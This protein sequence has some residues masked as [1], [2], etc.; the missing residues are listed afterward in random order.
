MTLVKRSALALIVFTSLAGVSPA[1]AA[2]EPP[3]VTAILK[4]WE[5]QLKVKPTYQS[6]TTESDG[7]VVID[8][9]SANLAVPN[10]PA[11]KMSVSVGKIK[12]SG[13]SDKGNGLFE[14]ASAQYTDTK[15]DMGTPEAGFNITVPQSSAEYW[16]V[17]ALG[18]NPTPADTLRANMNIA[19]KMSAGTMTLTAAGQT[20][21]ADG[22]EMTWDGDPATGSGKT[23]FKIV[24]ITIPEAAIAALDPSGMLKQLGYS[25]LAF[26]IGGNGD[27]DIGADKM[28]FNFDMFY[29]GKDMGTLKI[30]AGMGEIPAALL[31]ELQKLEGQAQPD[32][33]KFMPLVQGIQVSR[34]T[35]RFEDQSI[36]K[37]MIPL[38]AKMQNM[39]E[40]TMVANAGAMLQLGLAELKNPTFT[41]KAVEAVNAYLKDPRSLTILAKPA[42]PVTVQQLMALDPNNPGAAIDQLGVTISAND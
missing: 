42:Q 34:V 17:K 2:E 1:F 38:L 40:A 8:G 9:L 32:P 24:N 21:S 10:D 16:Y 5:S 30:G 22:Y 20:Y 29:T 26:D 18:D 36:T 13:I 27:I 14:V 35:F 28:G 7:S 6:L 31:A 23:D 12:L 39:D 37:K 41:Q 25:S 15:V 3:L 4:T 11:G 19:K 33:N